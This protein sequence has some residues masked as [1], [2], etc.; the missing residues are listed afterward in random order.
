MS[1]T[2]DQNNPAIL[3]VGHGSRD[4]EA[5]EEFNKM[6]AKLKALNP[7]RKCEVGFLE[8]ATPLIEEGVK[9]LLDQG[10][11]DIT[12]IPGMLMAAGHAK[13]DPGRDVTLPQ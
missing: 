6:V 2:D 12:A 1:G 8:F 4:V 7:D 5:I 13:N 10:A 9:A 3:V 11:Q